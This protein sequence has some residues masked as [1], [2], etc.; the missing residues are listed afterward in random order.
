MIGMAY[1]I[2]THNLNK[3]DIYKLSKAA[4]LYSIVRVNLPAEATNDECSA[5]L[6]NLKAP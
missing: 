4:D 6:D 1:F 5:F 2:E 3:A